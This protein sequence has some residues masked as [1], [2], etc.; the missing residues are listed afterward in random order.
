MS[1]LNKLGGIRRGAL[2]LSLSDSK[3]PIGLYTKILSIMDVYQIK[4]VS[5]ES[6][7]RFLDLQPSISRSELLALK[8]AKPALFLVYTQEYT[9]LSPLLK[10]G[11]TE[12]WG[13]DT[14]SLVDPVGI[15]K[16]K[17][18]L[19]LPF[20]PPLREDTYAQRIYDTTRDRLG[21]A[22]N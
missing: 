11:E 20:I 2:L 21:G 6:L 5:I 22:I 14:E 1:S 13:F 18:V 17:Y 19:T 16:K 8:L 7:R 9:Y 3:V 4:E 12:H 15:Y 10:I